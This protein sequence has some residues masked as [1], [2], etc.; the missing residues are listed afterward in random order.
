MTSDPIGEPR[1]SGHRVCLLAADY[2]G[3]EHP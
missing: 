1:W 3:V 2:D